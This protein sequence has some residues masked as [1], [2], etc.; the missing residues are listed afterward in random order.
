MDYE[1][2][3][4]VVVV[5]NFDSLFFRLRSLLYFNYGMS[6]ELQKKKNTIPKYSFLWFKMSKKNTFEHF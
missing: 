3:V 5:V 6:G 1:R 4:N 2:F